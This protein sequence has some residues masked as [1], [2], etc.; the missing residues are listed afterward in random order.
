MRMPVLA[1]GQLTM[2]AEFLAGPVLN[3]THLIIL[4]IHFYIVN[5]LGEILRSLPHPK[6]QQIVKL[7]VF[8]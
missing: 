2:Q 5:I 6:P 1:K 3:E 8:N 7:Q 4:I